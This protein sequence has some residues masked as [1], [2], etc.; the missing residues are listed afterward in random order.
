M[1]LSVFPAPSGGYLPEG[2]NSAVF[3]SIAPTGTGM[4]SG[5]YPAGTYI[6]S[7]G[8]SGSTI[9]A[10]EIGLT[11]T[12][13][14]NGTA[15]INHS[16]ATATRIQVQK[17]NV[18]S[19]LPSSPNGPFNNNPIISE[20]GL[21]YGNYNGTTPTYMYTGLA[22]GVAIVGRSTNDGVSWSNITSQSGI[23]GSSY[24]TVGFINNRWLLNNPT[25]YRTSDDNGNTWTGR[26]MPISSTKPRA[27]ITNSTQTQ[28][29]A[30]GPSGAIRYSS[31]GISWNTASNPQGSNQ[32]NGGWHGNGIY[33]LVGDGGVI[34]TSSDGI[35]WTQRT[36]GTT[37][38]LQGVAFG[39]GIWAIVGPS[40]LLQSTNN[41]VTWTSFTPPWGGGN[42]TNVVY[43]SGLWMVASV[44]GA[45]FYMSADGFR[46]AFLPASGTF[47]S[48]SNTYGLASSPN[49]VVIGGFNTFGNRATFSGNG[50]FMYSSTVQSLQ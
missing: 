4:I 9:L 31:D 39:N 46:N 8:V 29:L 12:T 21:A 22:N 16:G 48:L 32:L 15:I 27:F 13:G 30:V 37:N 25:Q 17:N 11:T 38:D 44:S 40:T 50:I 14:S 2:G 5:S 33:V 35:S 23:T 10:P 42:L 3:S 24:T 34:L 6:V 49:S 36:S 28:V 26:T 41:G 19:S 47:P 1:G 18:F 20:G 45:T 7:T 43:N